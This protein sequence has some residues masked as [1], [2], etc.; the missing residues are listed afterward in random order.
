MAHMDPNTPEAIAFVADYLDP[1]NPAYTASDVLHDWAFH[2]E[3]C[4][5]A[6]SEASDV[7]YG[8][9]NDRLCR[10]CCEG[11]NAAR[12]FSRSDR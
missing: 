9:N 5:A 1:L 6:F 4:D 7:G 10:E 12:F 3:D 2:C 11:A 8:E